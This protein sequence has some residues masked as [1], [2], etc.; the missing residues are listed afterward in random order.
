VV[1]EDELAESKTVRKEHLAGKAGSSEKGRQSWSERR[2]VN[3]QA[4]VLWSAGSLKLDAY[5]QAVEQRTA[6]ER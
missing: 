1:V 3:V 5:E 4:L 2:N 6:A